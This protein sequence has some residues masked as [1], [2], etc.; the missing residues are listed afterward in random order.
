MALIGPGNPRCTLQWVRPV[1][2]D[3]ECHSDRIANQVHILQS[4]H[5]AHSGKH[6]RSPCTGLVQNCRCKPPHR[7]RFRK[8]R[9]HYKV[10]Q[11]SDTESHTPHRAQPLL[12]RGKWFHRVSRGE[13]SLRYKLPTH[14]ALSHI[15]RFLGSQSSR[16]LQRN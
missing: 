2:S 6:R 13:N 9:I 14:K 11:P 16:D 8:G 10:T 3:K 1:G 15:H 4:K 12:G 7:G 5:R